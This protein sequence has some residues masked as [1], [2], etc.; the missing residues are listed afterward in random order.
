M[1]QYLVPKYVQAGKLKG[2]PK[3]HKT[4]AP[5]RTI[6]SGIDTPTERITELEEH[7]L[8]EFVESTPRYVTIEILPTL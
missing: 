2:N 1:Q 6:V 8:K 5:L 4:D 7:E 3:F